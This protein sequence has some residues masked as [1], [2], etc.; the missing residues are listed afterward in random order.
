[1]KLKPNYNY[2]GRQKLDYSKL[3]PFMAEF[4]DAY[5]ARIFNVS[6]ERIRQLR[7]KWKIPVP[8]VK[9]ICHINSMSLDNATTIFAMLKDKKN[10]TEIAKKIGRKKASISLF[11]RSHGTKIT[12]FH[13][14]FNRSK[15]IMRKP[16]ELRK[17]KQMYAEGKTIYMIGKT[18]DVTMKTAYDWQKAGHFDDIEII[19]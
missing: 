18:L 10:L 16:D 2:D 17:A 8:K 19:K 13:T 14:D 6:R 9:Q 1:M 15:G 11:L 5:C 7:I 12:D 4:Y 3:K